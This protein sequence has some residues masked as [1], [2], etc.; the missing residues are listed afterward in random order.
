LYIQ[1]KQPPPNS[2]LL[3]AGV[4]VVLTLVAIFG[5]ALLSAPERLVA[6]FPVPQ[7]LTPTPTAL[8]EATPETTPTATAT[9]RPT[10]TRTPTLT[11]TPQATLAPSAT[12][13][14]VVE[15]FMFGRPVGEDAPSNIPDRTYLYGATGRG[16]YEVHH[17]EEFI[18]PLGTGVV[19][20]S[21][22]TVIVAGH[23]E[24]PLCGAGGNEVCGAFPDYYGNVI[25][26]RL[27]RAYEGTPVF[28]VYGHLSRVHVRP[29][30]RVSAGE[31]IGEVGAEGFAIGPHLHFE[32]RYG[33]SSIRETRNPTLW[34]VPLPGTGVIAGRL[35][36]RM[37]EPIRGAAIIVYADDEFGTYLFDTETYARDRAPVVN[38]DDLMQENWAIPDVPAGNYV[39]KAFVGGLV[40]SRRVTVEPGRL[41][42]VSFSSK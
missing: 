37:G 32:V 10:Q 2:N 31:N 6:A 30:Q 4:A 12:P 23:D 41:V 26:I 16:Q 34:M 1:R 13:Q 3:F 39:V 5:Y 19:A 18:N 27:D 9:R 14:P 24:L 11:R 20:V 40:Y 21:D 29:G 25:I 42:F 28:A 8:F 36:N 7:L 17:G 33:E 15:H 38:G 35:Q 22:G